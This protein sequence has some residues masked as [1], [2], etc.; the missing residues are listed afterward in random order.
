MP[1]NCRRFIVSVHIPEGP[2]V[3]SSGLIPE[4][5]EVRVQNKRKLKVLAREMANTENYADW[6]AAARQYDDMTGMTDWRHVE[7]TDLYDYAQIRL[8]L[9]TLRNFRAR[10]AHQ[11]LLYALIEGING[12]M[13]GMGK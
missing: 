4:W 8:R 6:L 7:H 3:I 12:N 5:Y 9:D 13:E 10:S 11:G 2:T 1:R